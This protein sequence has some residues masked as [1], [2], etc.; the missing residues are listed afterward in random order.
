MSVFASLCMGVLAHSPRFQELVEPLENCL[1]DSHQG[2]G[3][4]PDALRATLVVRSEDAVG[5]APMCFTEGCLRAQ[6]LVQ[7]AWS[8]EVLLTPVIPKMLRLT[9]QV[10]SRLVQHGRQLCSQDSVGPSSLLTWQLDLHA[11]CQ[12]V[13]VP[14]HAPRVIETQ[15][16][17][18]F[19]LM[20]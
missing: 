2:T 1:S 9:M 6:L 10:V 14:N 7:R 19:S 18:V 3:R 8:S 16:P 15:H 5:A 4:A 13:S 20:K 11:L 17:L 12:F